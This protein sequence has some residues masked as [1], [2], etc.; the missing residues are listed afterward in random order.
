LV[1]D[2]VVTKRAAYFTDSLTRSCTRC[3][4]ARDGAIGV[5][6]TLAL[7]GPAAA[8]AGFPNLN[9][10]AANRDCKVPIV[11]HS[12]LG[13]IIALRREQID[14]DSWR[15]CPA[16]IDGILLDDRTLWV[17]EN[18]AERSLEV[19][20]DRDLASSR[21]ESVLND[22]DKRPRPRADDGGR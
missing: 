2:V 3:R 13:G 10:I 7:S 22:A 5:P 1:Y 14:R 18:F 17:V 11:A 8:I 6:Q 20:L 19:R 9:G 16:R 21:I 12:S 4:S 15:V